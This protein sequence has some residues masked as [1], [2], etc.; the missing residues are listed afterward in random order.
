MI[1]KAN[2]TLAEGISKEAKDLLKNS[3]ILEISKELLLEIQNFD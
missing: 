1:I 3:K 2:F